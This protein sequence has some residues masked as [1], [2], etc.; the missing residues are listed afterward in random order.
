MALHLKVNIGGE[1]DED[2]SPFDY[3]PSF[4]RFLSLTTGRPEWGSSA[5]GKEEQLVGSTCSHFLR[6]VLLGQPCSCRHQPWAPSGQW[7]LL[8]QGKQVYPD[9]DETSPLTEWSCRLLCSQ[10][11]LFPPCSVFCH[12]NDGALLMSYYE[13]K[14]QHYDTTKNKNNI[15]KMPLKLISIPYKISKKKSKSKDLVK[16]RG[17]EVQN[18]ILLPP[19]CESP[20]K[21]NPFSSVCYFGQS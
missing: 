11:W 20:W 1:E 8:K 5:Q 9:M 18:H 6:P 19:W 14:L 21:L 13:I 12:L 15:I 10:G 16:P 2:V 17:I 7:S 3:L 4:C